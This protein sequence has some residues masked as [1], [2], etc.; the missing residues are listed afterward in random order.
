MGELTKKTDLRVWL[1][2]IDTTR[3]ELIASAKGG[4]RVA[5]AFA[6]A[7]ARCDLV[8][9]LK[10]EQIRAKLLRMTDPEIA[11]V[12]L[13][14]NP[15][16]EDRIRVCA[17]A[18]LS[19]FTPGDDQFAVFGGGKNPGK[20]YVKERG[21]RTLFS[22]LGIVPEVRTSHPE[23]AAL[24]TSGK[25]IWRVGGHAS[26]T[27]QGAEYAID[28][29]GD[30]SIGIPGYDSDN[31]AGI[32]AKA[33]RRLLQALWIKVSPILST[34]QYD[35]DVETVAVT[36]HPEVKVIQQETQ[37]EQK[38]LQT[39]WAQVLDMILI[40]IDDEAER[41]GFKRLWDS[42]EKSKTAKALDECV[43]EIEDAKPLHSER[44]IIELRRFFKHRKGQL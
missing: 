23:F 5:A 8:D 15:S 29:S 9:S 35:E 34:D 10:D 22:H 6:M 40:R 14:N 36:E 42:V 30:E 38:P 11:M 43:K 26:C 33:R 32:A 2:R 1:D 28:C 24:G 7:D 20:L 12:E 3:N 44:N 13:A 39:D 31:V 25:K 27:Y 18:I 21:F 41:D 19:G 4:N 17:I 37:K 16:H